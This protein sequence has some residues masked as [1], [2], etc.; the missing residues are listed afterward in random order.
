MYNI[1]WKEVIEHLT[2][3]GHSVSVFVCAFVTGEERKAWRNEGVDDCTLVFLP[4][5]SLFW[6][7]QLRL[8]SSSSPNSIQWHCHVAP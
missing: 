5:P 1:M 4:I 7:H 3:Q 2:G 8:Y 6:K